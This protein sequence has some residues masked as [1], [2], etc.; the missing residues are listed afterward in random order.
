MK[1]LNLFYQEDMENIKKEICKLREEIESRRKM[2]ST[3]SQKKLIGFFKGMGV[4][5]SDA[6]VERNRNLLSAIKSNYSVAVEN[7]ERRS[8]VN[9]Y[10]RLCNIS[11]E[12]K[13]V[14]NYD[15][16]AFHCCVQCLKS[17]KLRKNTEMSRRDECVAKEIEISKEVALL[18]NDLVM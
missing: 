10:R 1:K 12:K 8:I 13:E 17:S 4:L 15:V 6:F 3:A 2:E 16:N 11:S 7:S 9:E 5:S 14:I 18:E